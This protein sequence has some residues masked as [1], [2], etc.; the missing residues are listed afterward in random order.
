M[1]TPLIT[2]VI[3]HYKTLTLT[4]LCLRLLRHHSKRQQI[5][6]IVVDND[7]QDESLPWLRSLPWITLIERK[8]TPD[9]PPQLCHSRALD[10]ALEVTTTPYLLAIHTDTLIKRS[11]WLDFLLK[12]IEKDENIAAVGSWKLEH[13]SCPARVLKSIEGT[14]QQIWFRLRGRQDKLERNSNRYLRCHCALYRVEA[15]KRNNFIFVSGEN[16]P[17]QTMHRQLTSK[18]YDM[19]FLSSRQLSR[20]IEHVTHATMILNPE[21]N[22]KQSRQTEGQQRMKRIMKEFNADKVLAEEHLDGE[23][24]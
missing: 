16:P 19:I 4:K 15:I 1:T 18:G 11:D 9:E 5:E 20:Y 7:S 13:R 21:F 2:V 22:L 24:Q 6:V 10:A 23:W 17:G 3:P 8:H 12:Q 14:W